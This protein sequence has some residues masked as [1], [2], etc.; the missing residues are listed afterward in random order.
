VTVTIGD[1]QLYQN[2]HGADYQC[3]LLNSLLTIFGVASRPA[4]KKI[5]R[6]FVGC[7]T[8]N[9]YGPALMRRT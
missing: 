8:W 7:D 2:G 9:Q 1:E 3:Y 5:L 6:R 4:A